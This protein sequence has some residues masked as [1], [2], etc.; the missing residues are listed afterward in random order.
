MKIAKRIGMSRVSRSG[1]YQQLFRL[2]EPLED[3]YTVL[4]SSVVA[5]DTSEPETYIFGADV[6]GN[7]LKWGE[8]DGSF[9]GGADHAEAL[10]R[11]GYEI[12][13]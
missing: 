10:R 6:E 3:Y 5:V 9:R 11:A 8:L 7:I 4:V 13:E 2:S 1:A 12:E